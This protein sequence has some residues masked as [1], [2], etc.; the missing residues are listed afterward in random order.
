MKRKRLLFGFKFEL[1]PHVG[2]HIKE[3]V[4]NKT[5]FL[6][7]ELANLANEFSNEIV[8]F[9]QGIFYIFFAQNINVSMALFGICPKI[10]KPL[11][12]I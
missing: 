12:K 7:S 10:A 9:L 4:F 2:R 3:S 6:N 5:A 11:K 1:R 8:I